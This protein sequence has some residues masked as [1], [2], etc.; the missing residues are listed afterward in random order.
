MPTVRPNKATL[1]LTGSNVSVG[2]TISPQS[3]SVTLFGHYGAASTGVDPVTVEP[4]A[5][6]LSVTG[7]VGEVVRP[8]GPQPAALVLSGH[9]PVAAT[10]LVDTSAA[11]LDQCEQIW[12]A[13]RRLRRQEDALRRQQPL[14]RVWDAEWELQHLM[15]IDYRS[16]F[17]WISNDSGP[18]QS[19][20]PFDSPLAE[21]IHDMQGRI[22]RGENRNVHITVDYCGARWSG[23]LDK[24]SVEQRDDGDVV[25][26]VDW[27]NDYENTKW[28]ACWS[29][30]FLP[31]FIQFPRVWLLPGPITWI[32]KLTMFLNLFR[33]HNPLVVLP[34]DP[35]DFTSWFTNLD[36]STWQMVVKPQSFL[37]GLGS[38]V[39][40]G[41]VSS[42]WKTWH[43]MAHTML[44]DGE[45]SVECRRYLPGD[46]PPWPGANLRYGTLVFDLIDKSGVHVG[47]SNGGSIFDGLFRT[48]AEFT[49]DFLDSTD[50]LIVDADTPEDYFLPG[51]KLTKKEKPYVVFR[52]GDSSPIQSSSYIVS[53]AKGV[54]V[55]VGGKSM[56]GVNEAISASIQAAGDILG[57][58]VQIGS[59]GGTIDTLVKPIYEDTILAW[60]SVKNFLRAQHSGWSRYE[61]YFQDGADKAYTI[62]SLMVL[63]AGFWA[64]KTTVSWKV[65]VV[66][67]LPF[68]I[69]DNGLG[70]FFLDDRIGLVLRGDSKIH[71]DRCRK[72]ELAWDEQ[73][74]PEWQITIGDE[75]V[76]QDP[77]QRAWGKIE[78]IVSALKD[79]GV[80]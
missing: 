5:A 9:P 55:N 62:A 22:E 26:V 31:A 12:E 20:I 42:R 68:L 51:L 54:I 60:W 76:H 36:Q 11:L 79:L 43:D 77:A 18:G 6:D 56:P 38:G 24:Y 34:D 78:A 28:I 15:T 48:V 35:L 30:P 58:V 46:E 10:T 75:R 23:R 37:E 44:E 65:N 69:G 50:E 71:V 17:S 14:V 2:L 64:T 13:T 61:E 21:W 32:L 47:T 66:D 41:L 39:V 33:H 80:Y 27:L 67:G 53:P 8:V 16:T 63:R 29:N 74:P 70:H 7:G 52:E 19:E 4:G 49:D 57:S 72:L 3:A 40:W 1:T 73:T 45:L 25:M 59:L